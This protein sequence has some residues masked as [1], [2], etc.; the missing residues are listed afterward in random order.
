MILAVRGGN[1]ELRFGEAMARIPSPIQYAGSAAGQPVTTDSATGLT[2][3]GRA[4]RL[5]AGMA[6]SMPIRVYQGRRGEKRELPDA[7]QAR[8]LEEP[9]FGHSD[10]DWRWDIVSS[11]EASENAYLL[12]R[13]LRGRVVELEYIPYYAV[14]ASLNRRTGEKEYVIHLQ[15]GRETFPPEDIL[16]IRGQTVGG[17]PFGVSRITQHRDP[18]GSMLAAQRFEGA[19]FR[20]NARPDIAIIFP[21][22]VTREQ[23]AQ[24]RV[25]WE[26]QYG[27]AE[28]AGRA[29]PLGG[30]ATIQPIPISLEDAQFVE[31]RKLGIEDGG[32]IMDVDPVLLGAD[33]DRK[34]AL[35]TFLHV[36]L[37]ARLRRIE[38]ALRA[39]PDL[40][41]GT[42]L[43][44]EFEVNE[45]MFADPL[46]R[47]QVQHYRI[48]N[49]SELVDEARADNGR[50]PLPPIPADP[51]AEPGKVPQITPVGGAPTLPVPTTNTEPVRALRAAEPQRELVVVNM[52]TDTMGI[53]DGLRE[54]AAAQRQQ[55]PQVIHVMAPEVIVEQPAITVE[56]PS[57]TVEPAVVNLS[58]EIRLE[59]PSRTV[60]VR[61][62]DGTAATYTE[63]SD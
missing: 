11:L 10:F 38:R 25:E 44:P 9:M 16:H 18:L 63:E 59:V 54:L 61:R 3:I 56:S 15:S 12:K 60:T 62:D 29:V 31:T 28:N 24:W 52:P 7:W 32:R 57:V 43:Y 1:R 33:G 13:K 34:M 49:G 21:Q 58:P 22:G 55:E 47:A 53:A 4:L 50:G 2:V 42:D 48:Q 5:V 17:G 46:T 39:D 35:Q 40:F 26:A 37:P 14:Q 30:G 51:A 36:Q 41:G 19:F 8:L 6:A 20:N 45:L 23:A 27:G